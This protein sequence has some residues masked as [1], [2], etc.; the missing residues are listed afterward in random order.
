M[1]NIIIIIYDLS[2][3]VETETWWG[4]IK[5]VLVFLL[6]WWWVDD[7]LFCLEE[8]TCYSGGGGCLCVGG[9]YVHAIICNVC[10]QTPVSFHL[11]FSFCL[12]HMAHTFPF[13]F[14]YARAREFHCYSMC[15]ELSI[16]LGSLLVFYLI[17]PSHCRCYVIVHFIPFLVYFT[18]YYSI[19]VRL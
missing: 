8:E 16:Y 2:C 18:T 10:Q 7:I 1:H 5:V 6:R 17:L 3:L 19:H 4:S 15:V 12:P 14:K 9:S 13:K 11:L